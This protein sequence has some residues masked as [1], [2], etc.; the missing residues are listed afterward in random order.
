[1]FN[2]PWPSLFK[3]SVSC[4]NS[5]LQ[6]LHQLAKKTINVG[7]LIKSDLLTF[8]PL[9]GSASISWFLIVSVNENPWRASEGELKNAGIAVK[10][11]NLDDAGSYRDHLKD[12]DTVFMVQAFEQGHKSEIL[13]GKAFIDEAKA[14]LV[15]SM[16]IS[17]VAS[18]DIP[19]NVIVTG[20]IDAQPHRFKVRPAPGGVSVGHPRVTAGTLGC[21]ARGRRAP[22]NRRILLLSNNH[23]IANSND[24]KSPR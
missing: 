9:T 20:V 1:M 23:V 13:Q 16:G 4:T 12:I 6:V 8:I 10:Q 24:A 3:Y 15:D 5:L 14:A 7:L 2:L 18:D 19:V 21:L 17:A 22:R 11:G